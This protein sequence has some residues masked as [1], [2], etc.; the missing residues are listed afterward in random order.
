MQKILVTGGAG[1]IGSQMV[2]LLIQRGY[3]VIVLDNLA[4]GFREA[5]DEKAKLVVGDFGDQKLLDRLFSQHKFAAVMHFAAF[6]EVGESVNNPVKYYQ[7]NVENTL[8]L[9]AAMANYKVNNLIFSS[10]AAI[11][12]QP[13]YTPLDE[14]HPKQPINPYG[15]SKLII[16]QILPDY[17]KAYGLKSISLR[18]FNAAGADPKGRFGPRHEPASHLIPLVLQ[19]ASGYKENVKIFGTD[20]DTPDGTCIRDYI[21]V[22]D[23]CEA[24]LLALTKLFAGS[25]S[26]AYNLGNGNGFSVFEVIETAKKVTKRPFTVIECDRRSGDAAVLIADAKKAEQELGWKPKY[27]E[28]ET[29]VR[30][31]WQWELQQRT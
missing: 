3:E 31:A 12:G 11:Y 20:Y 4:T 13:E 14:A 8:H 5:V 6:I 16:E 27:P 23:L 29:I 24:H 7:N 30:H 22:A 28:L 10:S 1:Y 21:H 25:E 2:D 15:L 17:D 9:L 18:Y 19:A 26:N